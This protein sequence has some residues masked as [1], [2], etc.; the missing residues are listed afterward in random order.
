MKLSQAIRENAKL[1][2]QV[3]ILTRLDVFKSLL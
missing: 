3:L 2:P 1:R